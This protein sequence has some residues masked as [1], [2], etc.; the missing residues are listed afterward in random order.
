MLRAGCPE[1]PS[2]ILAAQEDVCA[3][4]GRGDSREGH[5]EMPP[6]LPS[7]VGPSQDT[8]DKTHKHLA[9]QLP[10]LRSQLPCVTS[11]KTN[12][13]LAAP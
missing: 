10:W 13:V 4:G 2:T 8:Q 12:P 9:H 5:L 11:R 1:N 3:I 7:S 6:P